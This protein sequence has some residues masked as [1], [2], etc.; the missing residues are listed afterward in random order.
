MS[1]APTGRRWTA[2]RRP[3][4]VLGAA[5][6]LVGGGLFAHRQLSP[7]FEAAGVL[8]VT[9]E[10]APA[11]V[12]TTSSAAVRPP[13]VALPD[14]SFTPTRLAMDSPAVA[15]RV[16]P[17]EV[18]PDRSLAIPTD[19]HEVGWWSGGAA[20]G[21]PVGTVVLAGHV[22]SARSGRG[23]LFDL[24][25]AAI[26]S[27]V[28]LSGPTGEQSYVVQARRR[29]LKADLPWR[30]LFA[31]RETPSLVLVTCG[32]R[33]TRRPGTTPTTSSSSPSLGA[34][35]RRRSRRPAEDAPSSS[36]DSPSR[37]PRSADQI[38]W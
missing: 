31:Q 11:T 24:G 36:V 4:A 2:A 32:G 30:E 35:S 8:P 6:V 13:V 18:Q 16:R 3:T 29:Y 5:L 14:L 22:D 19:V 15:A 26:G 38:S 27:Q 20:P 7:R 9:A 12:P 25:Q 21:S 1:P 10:P 17:V 37:Q 23:A 34:Q 33:S 28:T